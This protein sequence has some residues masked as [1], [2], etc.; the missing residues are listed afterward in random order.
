MDFSGWHD[1]ILDKKQ[2]KGGKMPFDLL[3]MQHIMEEKEDMV[4]GNLWVTGMGNLS[5]SYLSEGTR[6]QVRSGAWP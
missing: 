3:C 5:L 4:A 1:Q 2:F 6:N